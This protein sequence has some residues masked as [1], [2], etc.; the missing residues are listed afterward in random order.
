MKSP[1]VNNETNPFDEPERTIVWKAWDECILPHPCLLETT[2]SK[3]MEVVQKIFDRVIEP[4]LNRGIDR[5]VYCTGCESFISLYDS[6]LLDTSHPLDQLL[7]ISDFVKLYHVY[8]EKDVYHWM[9]KNLIHLNNNFYPPLHFIK[10]PGMNR[11]HYTYIDAKK[12][13]EVASKTDLEKVYLSFQLATK[14]ILI[15]KLL[16]DYE[17]AIEE[18]T[19]L[20][21]MLLSFNDAFANYSVERQD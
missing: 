11:F 6:I 10:R 1:D 3:V 7:K 4:Y 14:D 21:A 19:N 18:R 16:L 5:M 8:S 13:K 9:L 12:M 15:E 20:Q 2:G 17:N